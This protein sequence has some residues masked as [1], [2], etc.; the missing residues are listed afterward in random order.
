MTAHS[1]TPCSLPRRNMDCSSRSTERLARNDGVSSLQEAEPS[2]HC[3]GGA[4]SNPD[5][6]CRVMVTARSAALI[7]PSPCLIPRRNMDCSSRSTE[8][9]A[10]NDG[11]SSLQEA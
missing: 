5:G 8:R 4:R 2:R 3:E 10:R 9:L 6:K 7:S 1:A 11:V